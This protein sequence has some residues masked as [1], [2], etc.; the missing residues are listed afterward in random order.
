MQVCTLPQ[1]VHHW[2]GRV[3][4]NTSHMCYTSGA[5]LCVHWLLVVYVAWE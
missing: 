2:P 1:S 3:V 4:I 5:F